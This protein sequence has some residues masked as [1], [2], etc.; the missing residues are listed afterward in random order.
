MVLGPSREVPSRTSRYIKIKWEGRESEFR[1]SQATLVPLLCAVLTKSSGSTG[2]SASTPTLG[3][4]AQVGL[5]VL[6]F[7]WV[8]G[9]V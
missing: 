4:E 8:L 2:G 1:D 7:S 5:S 6:R 9:L 3:T